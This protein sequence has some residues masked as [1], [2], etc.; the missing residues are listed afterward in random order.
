MTSEEVE[1]LR[2]IVDEADQI[3]KDLDRLKKVDILDDWRAISWYKEGKS[4]LP[5]DL[6]KVIVIAGYYSVKDNLEMKLSELVPQPINSVIRI[7][8]NVD[9]FEVRE[10]SNNY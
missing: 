9:T 7:P 1:K 2:S 10:R 3:L 6:I 5:S 8:E 4:V